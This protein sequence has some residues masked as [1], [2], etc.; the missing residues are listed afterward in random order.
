VTTLVTG[1]TGFVGSR[2][3]RA[4][5]AR[6][7]AVRV[8]ARAGADRRNLEGLAVEVVTGDLRERASLDPALRGVSTLFHAAADYRLWS[9]RPEALYET[10]VEGTRRLMH[11]AAAAGVERIAYTSSVATL[12]STADGTPADERTPASLADMIGHYKRSK[13]LAEQAVREMIAAEGL[14]CVIVNP[15][16]PVGPGDIKPTPTGRMVRDAARGAMPACVDTGLNIVHVDDVA[17]GHLLALE[18]GRPGE[19]YILGGENMTLE[20]ILTICAALAGRR[21]PAVR[22][23]LAAVY[24]VAWLSELAARLAGSGE[25]RVTVDSLRMA[26]KPMFFS[27][28]K[29]R[30]ELG[31]APRPAREALAAAVAWF[32]SDLA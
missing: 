23:P 20:Q 4:L 19:R 14:P 16:T 28:G 30:R 31:Y 17:A 27:S 22:L 7:E 11:A 10:N 8:L 24:P 9:P 25:P 1:A 32:T 26:R 3:A 21:P 12:G 13:F 5:L 6:G 2:I 18:K 29:A 15:S